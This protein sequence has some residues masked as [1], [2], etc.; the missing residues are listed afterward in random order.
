MAAKERK[1]RKKQS[2]GV[3]SA[4]EFPNLC[5]L[6]FLLSIVASFRGKK[7]VSVRFSVAVSCRFKFVLI[8]A[9]RVKVFVFIRS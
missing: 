8:R 9:I 4:G 1:E 5:S 6:R 2:E 3:I 7:Q